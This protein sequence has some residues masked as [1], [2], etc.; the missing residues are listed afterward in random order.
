MT[1]YNFLSI[2]FANWNP[3]WRGVYRFKWFPPKNAF[4]KKT[5][6]KTCPSD[7]D[8]IQVSVGYYFWFTSSDWPAG[9]VK[10]TSQFNWNPMAILQRALRSGAISRTPEDFAKD[11]KTSFWPNERFAK[12]APHWK[13]SPKKKW[14]AKKPSIFLKAPFFLPG[15]FLCSTPTNHH[16]IPSQAFVMRI[17][18]AQPPSNGT[19]PPRTSLPC[20]MGYEKQP[21]TLNNPLIPQ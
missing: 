19:V 12:N 1:T 10:N 18:G 7:W 4:T 16:P 17:Q 2:E 5:S 21:W 6:S 15:R 11:E 8:M 20:Y 13:T 9:M 3:G 14:V